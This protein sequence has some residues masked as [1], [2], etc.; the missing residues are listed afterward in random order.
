MRL[1]CI[2]KN[3]KKDC[4]VCHYINNN[5][6]IKTQTQH[7]HWSFNPKKNSTQ[8]RTATLSSCFLRV[9]KQHKTT[10]TKRDRDW[11]LWDCRPPRTDSHQSA[12]IV[13]TACWFRCGGPSLL[14][15]WSLSPSDANWLPSFSSPCDQSHS[16]HQT[17]NNHGDGGQWLR[18]MFRL[19]RNST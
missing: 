13:S 18:F 12:I 1:I 15:S 11:N 9:A 5:N 16:Q 6:I 8:K 19:D 10:T 17:T 2:S 7:S 3:C 4:I 14:F